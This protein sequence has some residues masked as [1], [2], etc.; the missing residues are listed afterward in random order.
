MRILLLLLPLLLL[1]YRVELKEWGNQTFYSFLKT[2][3]IPISLFYKLDKKIQKKLSLIPKN[4]DIYLLRDFDKIKQALIPIDDKNQLQIIRQKDKYITKIIPIHYIIEDDVVSVNVENFLSYD[5]YRV[6]KNPLITQ[7]LVDI[8]N[9]RVNFRVLPKNSKVDIYYKTKSRFGKVVDIDII[10]AKIE[11]RY[12]TIS[13][14]K[15]SDGRYYDENGKSLKG[16]FLPYPMRYTKISSGFGMRFHPIL[17]RMRMHDGI[18]YVN[19]IGTPIKS[20]ADG[21]VIYKGWLGG[22]GK[23][24]KIKHKNGYITLYAH[25]K[26]YSKIRIGQYVKQGQVIGYMGNTGMSTGPHLHFGVMRYGKWINPIKI[27][28][29]AK[30]TLYGKNRRKFFDYVASINREVENRVA[31]K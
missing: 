26:G 30:I 17:H 5:I 12:Y 29:S 18:D 15:W 25:M 19:K 27:R 9:D 11:N 31:M 23:T 24:I 22:Y 13:A 3:H 28:K 6:T 20:V 21:R 16:M 8:F 4:R 7:K 14:Y 1:G 10:Y 2:N